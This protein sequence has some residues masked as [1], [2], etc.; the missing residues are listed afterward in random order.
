MNRKEFRAHLIKSGWVVNK[1]NKNILTNDKGRMRI[2]LKPKYYKA[3]I[4][5]D[6]NKWQKFRQSVYSIIKPGTE[7]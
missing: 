1:V 7:K 4:K 3:T 5:N 6:L 2:K